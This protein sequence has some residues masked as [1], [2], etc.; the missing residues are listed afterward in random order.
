[1]KPF[2][3]LLTFIFLLAPQIVGATAT[4]ELAEALA[5]KFAGQ[6]AKEFAE[7]GGE[8]ALRNVIA[9][10][11][12]EGGE[13]AASQAAGLC[14]RF[15]PS[16]IRA[17]EGSPARIAQSLGKLPDDLIEAGVRAAA[18][19]PQVVGKLVTQFG[20]DALLVAAKHPGVGTGIVEKLGADG[21]S[22][23]KN[24]ATPEAVRLARLADDIS[25][26]APNQRAAVI[27]KI[28]RT[29]SRALDYLERHPKLLLTGAG[30]SVFLAAK[31]D[32]LGTAQAPGFV[33]RIWK[34]SIDAFHNPLSI[35]FLAVSA[36]LFA[37]VAFIIVRI[38]KFR[39]QKR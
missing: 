29:G 39:R 30:V 12:S 36:M 18:R 21:V 16:V 7:A 35:L 33:E 8:T 25:A 27:S 31:D 32:I 14:E 26:V 22:L 23:S 2:L 1:M 11:A 3:H 28:Q 38:V 19:E 6:S 4:S 24:M 34:R 20:D 13:A 37:R 10:A 17:I 9:K 5:R 15:G